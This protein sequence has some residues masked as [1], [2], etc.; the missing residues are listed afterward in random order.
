MRKRLFRDYGDLPDEFDFD[1]ALDAFEHFDKRRHPGWQTD[2]NDSHL[3]D[4][5]TPKDRRRKPGA[6][7][8]RS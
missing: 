4:R 8:H 6:T 1:E 5:R 2:E 3:N 7:A